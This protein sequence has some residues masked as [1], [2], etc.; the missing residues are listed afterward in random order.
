MNTRLESMSHGDGKV[1]LQMVLDRLHA[2]A[3]VLLDARLKDGTRVPSHLFPFRPLEPS[4][5]ANYV[6]VLPHLDVREVDLSFVEYA[7]ADTPLSQSRLTVE[8]NMVKWRTRLNTL[9]HN[10]L[11][12]QMLDIEREYCVDRMSVYFTD[13][14]VDNDEIV[15]KMFVDMPHEDGSDVAVGFTDRVG[16]EIDLPVYPLMDEVCPQVRFGEEERLHV[17]FSVRVSVDARDFC[18]T[19]YDENHLVDGGFAVF[20]DETYEPLQEAFEGYG[21][22]AAHDERYEEWYSRH[23]ETLAGLAQQRR[24]TFPHQPLV[25]LVM[26]VY[27]GDE[28]YL[29][30]SL[31]AVR[32][33]T[34]PHFELVVVDVGETGFAYSSA[35]HE[36]DGDDRLVRVACEATLDEAAARCTGLLQ[37]KGDAVAVL[38]PNVILA[39]EA[40]FEYVR[41]VNEVLASEDPAHPADGAASE[42]AAD[43]TAGSEA[44]GD[45]GAADE[46]AASSEAVGVG[47]CD[48]TYVNHDLFGRDCG[49][50]APAFKPVWSPDLLC[51]YEYLGPLVF[52]SRHLVDAVSTGVGFA[53]EAFA[54][55]FALK[56]CE[57]AR[58]ID[59]IDR[60]L[61]HVQDAVSISASA[62]AI[63]ARRAEEAFRGGR[64]AVANHLRR[65]GAEAVVLS[66][67]AARCYRVR[68]RLPEK[69]P[70]L[71]IIV[72]G[73][74]RP[75]LLETCLASIVEHNDLTGSE[76][77]V[78]DDGSI[79]AEAHAF[80]DQQYSEGHPVR[81]VAYTGP[82]NQAAMR[83]AAARTCSSEYLLFL[84]CDT[85]MCLEDTCDLMLARAQRAD[86]GIVGAKLLFPD[87]TIQSA[88]VMVGPYGSSADIGVNLPRAQRGYARRFTCAHD[89][90]AVSSAALMVRRSLFEEVGG[91]DERFLAPGCEVDFCLKVRKAGYYVVYDGGIELYC[92]GH[93][94]AAPALRSADRLRAERE[95]GF[96]RYRWPRYFVEGD[97]FMSACFDAEVPYYHLGPFE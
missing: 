54:H 27:P 52:V 32:Q 26:P 10:E 63:R 55:D 29:A 7:G 5:H 1:Y 77:V 15:V 82:F 35:S 49:F 93:A 23:C 41:L 56:A 86:V 9:V 22:D 64:K 87:D 84:D 72:S 51:S 89:L 11:T 73:K 8:L 17:G 39:P 40:L 62:E 91:F 70:S 34:Y 78:V 81:L 20:C 48:V 59:R 37:S 68:Y 28:C 50:Y 6:V 46:A 94:A 95:R 88:G 12:A 30:A 92:Q 65:V 44:D 3:T 38:D 2:D 16:H 76:I 90:S 69:R 14:I 21:V 24:A 71:S 31:R 45:E 79:D 85:E 53:T 57:Q 97:P 33:Q 4:S 47:P 25:S 74:D 13:A 61:C 19:V 42:G 60:V 36:W 67:V 43:G 66:D 58:R 80:I 75:P 83:N 96:L 18:V